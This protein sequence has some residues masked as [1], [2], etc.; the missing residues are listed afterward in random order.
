MAEKKIAYLKHPV[1]PERKAEF[2]GKGFTIIDARFEPD[3]IGKNDHSEKS[4]IPKP[5]TQAKK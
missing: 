2:R 4:V 1:T 5:K 3:E